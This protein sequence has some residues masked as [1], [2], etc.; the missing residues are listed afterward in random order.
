MPAV[1]DKQ[2]TIPERGL[3]I[4]GRVLGQMR[5]GLEGLLRRRVHLVSDGIPYRFDNVPLAKVV[6]AILAEASCFFQ[7]GQPWA[8]PTHIMVE[9]ATFCNLRCVLCPVTQGLERPRGLMALSLFKKIM[10]EMGRYVFT[11]LL[12]DWG[13]PFLNPEVYDMIAYAKTTGVKVISS[14]NGHLFANR[15]QAEKLVDSGL[16]TIIFAIDG[17][18]PEI[19]RI[20]RQGGDLQTALEGLKMVAR[21]KQERGSRK[22]CLNFRFIV[23]RDNE[24]EIPKVRKVAR[25]MGADVLTFK[26]LNNCMPNFDHGE[27][28]V[29][30]NPFFIPRQAKYQRF[31]TDARGRLLRRRRNPCKQLWNHPVVHWNGNITPC[32]FDAHDRYTLGN[33]QEDSFRDIWW[34][35]PYREMR[36]QFR[37]DY[38]QIKLCNGCTYAFDGGS[39]AN[40]TIAEVILYETF[41]VA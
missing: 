33:L 35:E 21:V 6:N 26:T 10:D 18:S 28:A 19:Y 31:K 25:Q 22:P 4:G 34:G 7:P 11:L 13:E 27:T 20:F 29:L 24:Q 17:V 2:Q 39:C 14:T 8:W 15:T 1:L 3:R 38:R 12:W 5:Q 30:L 37:E 36:R 41:T 40:E 9:P 32:T 23:T 16:D